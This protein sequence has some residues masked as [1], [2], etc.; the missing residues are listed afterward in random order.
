MKTYQMF[1]ED[2]KSLNQRDQESKECF[3]DNLPEEEV[4]RN[5]SWNEMIRRLK[6]IYESEKREEIMK[7]LLSNP[8]HLDLIRRMSPS[9]D[10]HLN[11]VPRRTP[12]QSGRHRPSPR[13]R[14][15][16]LWG[17]R[18]TTEGVF[19]L[20]DWRHKK[21]GLNPLFLFS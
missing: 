8:T 2:Y 10:Q 3:Q 15:D 19:P 1:V 13:H 18:G 9:R 17:L 7:G 5:M 14:N 12:H 16:L 4:L 21:W 11:P 6:R 20:M